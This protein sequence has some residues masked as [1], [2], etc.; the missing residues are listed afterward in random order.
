VGELDRRFR[1]RQDAGRALGDEIRALGL[2]RPTMLALPRGGVPVGSE[3]ARALD[4]PFDVVVAR[5]IGMPGQPEYAIG[6]VAE[7][8]DGVVL[9]H[10]PEDIQLSR[11]RLKRAI[12]DAIG[13]VRRRVDCYRGGRALPDLTG[14][15]AVIVDDGLATGATAEAAIAAARGLHAREVVVAVPVGAPDTVARLS[16]L[17]RVVCL[18]T[19]ERFT[20]V[21]IWY[22]DFAQTTDAEV[23]ALLQR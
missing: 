11:E 7:E 20:A 6:A 16:E 8:T 18:S 2:R 22:D 23:L 14:R 9:H 21:G 5:K 15:T 3:V 12:D 17:A 19:P 4:A 10:R 13:E 1:N